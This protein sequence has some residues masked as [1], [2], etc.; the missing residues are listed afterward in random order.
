MK[1]FEQN[2]VSKR[3]KYQK[4]AFLNNQNLPFLILTI[5]RTKL[6][7]G[8]KLRTVSNTIPY[9]KGNATLRVENE[10]ARRSESNF[11]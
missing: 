6:F 1:P 9:R 8:K 7:T 4:K 3:K 2:R 11:C 10:K 5:L